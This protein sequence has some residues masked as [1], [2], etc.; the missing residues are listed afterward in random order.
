[1]KPTGNVKDNPSL[2]NLK[3]VSNTLAQ[4][5]AALANP[6]VDAA[7]RPQAALHPPAR[8]GAPYQPRR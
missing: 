6:G 8:T 2:L 1:M 7:G 4:Q 5:Q 3:P